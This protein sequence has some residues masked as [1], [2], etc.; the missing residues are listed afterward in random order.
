MYSSFVSIYMY[1]LE[2]TLGTDVSF[3]A[4]CRSLFDING[5]ENSS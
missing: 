3:R 5:G 1:F 2:I 4:K